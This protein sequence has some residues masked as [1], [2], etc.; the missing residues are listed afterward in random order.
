MWNGIGVLAGLLLIALIVWQ[1]LRLANIELEIGVTPAM[2]TAALAV[3]TLIFVF[4]RW[5]DKPG[6]G[7]VADASTGRSGSWL[8]LALAIVLVDRRLAEHAGRRRGPRPHQ[9]VRRR[10]HGGCAE[11]AVDRDDKPAAAAPAPQ[12]REPPPPPVETPADVPAEPP[13]EPI[14]PDDAPRAS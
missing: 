13:S 2:I 8:G 6:G 12:R 4:I 1:A 5:I 11:G 3:L 9:V 14:E 7:L 10:R